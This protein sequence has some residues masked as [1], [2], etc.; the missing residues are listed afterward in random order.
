[1]DQELASLRAKFM[2]QLNKFLAQILVISA[3]ASE[4]TS[5]AYNKVA[6]HLS[7]GAEKKSF[8]GSAALGMSV[9]SKLE[10]KMSQFQHLPMSHH[11]PHGSLVVMNLNN[12]VK[13]LSKSV[14]VRSKDTSM[15]LV[16]L[17]SPHL[18]LVSSA[19][20]DLMKN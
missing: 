8:Q 5:F 15:K 19:D 17:S 10:Y 1:L 14:A 20:V 4:V 9:L 18:D 16:P 2:S 3:S 7:L 6:L 13:S 11:W 12:Q